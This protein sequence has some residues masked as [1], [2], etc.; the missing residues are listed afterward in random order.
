MINS[1]IAKSK[2]NKSHIVKTDPGRG[3]GWSQRNRFENRLEVPWEPHT[4]ES[5]GD[6]Q[7]A[8]V[9]PDTITVSK[10]HFTNFKCF[11]VT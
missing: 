6:K 3:C 7:L 4:A 5:R 8:A 9:E 2:S 10:S 1:S 11:L